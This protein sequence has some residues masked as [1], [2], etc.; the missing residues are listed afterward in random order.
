M[1]GLDNFR[2]GAKKRWVAMVLQEGGAEH[3]EERR[4]HERLP[5][6]VDIHYGAFKDLSEIVIDQEGKLLDIGAGGICFLAKKHIEVATQIMLVLEFP[7]WQEGV[8][9]WQASSNDSDIGVLKV[10]GMVVRCLP[11]SLEPGLYEVGV[12]FCGRMKK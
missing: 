12:C 11:S 9:D 8:A 4:Q 10:V 1:S 2:R 7:G 6:D 3:F 5:K